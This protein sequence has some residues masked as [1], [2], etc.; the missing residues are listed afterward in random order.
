MDSA[1]ID[2]PLMKSEI[3]GNKVYREEVKDRTMEIPKR[4]IKDSV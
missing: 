2:D 3:R 4:Q 1:R